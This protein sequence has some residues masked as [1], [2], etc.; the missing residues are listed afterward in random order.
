MEGGAGIEPYPCVN[1]DQAVLAGLSALWGEARAALPASARIMRVGVVLMD[2]TLSNAR[3]LDMFLAD[4]LQ[5]Q[6]WERVTG[7]VDHLNRK[8]GARVVTLGPWTAPPGGFAGGKIAF[9][10]IPSA[11]DFL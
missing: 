2:L 3:Q 9:C 5:R 7:A 1:D 8:F 11:E 6:K 4:D 10:R